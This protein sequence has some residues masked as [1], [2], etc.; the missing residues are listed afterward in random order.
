MSKI[1]ALPLWTKSNT[2]RLMRRMRAEGILE[3][4]FRVE[5]WCVQHFLQSIAVSSHRAACKIQY[6][7][8]RL[9]HLNSVGSWMMRGEER[10]MT[11]FQWQCS[12]KKRVGMHFIVTKP[13]LY[14]SVFVFGESRIRLSEQRDWSN[15]LWLIKYQSERGSKWNTE[16]RAHC[17]W[18]KMSLLYSDAIIGYSILDTK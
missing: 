6:Q 3:D 14:R 13:F 12:F 10:R 16:I 17:S 7:L 11:V 9:S 15:P 18:I 8:I 4:W 5:I 2:L 1:N